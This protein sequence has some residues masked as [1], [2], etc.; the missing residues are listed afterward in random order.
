MP[1]KKQDP[2]YVPGDR[3]RAAFS[4]P[5][6][7][8]GVRL[9]PTATYVVTGEALNAALAEH[10]A[11]AIVAAEPFAGTHPPPGGLPGAE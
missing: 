5:V 9:A 10:G 1:S 4:T 2:V 7:I 11:A 8:S 3:Y 6:M